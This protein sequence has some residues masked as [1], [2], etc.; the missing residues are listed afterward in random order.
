MDPTPGDPDKS[1]T[2]LDRSGRGF[3]PRP[4]ERGSRFRGKGLIF[5]SFPNPPCN[6]NFA[7]VDRSGR[8]FNPRPARC[9]GE[10]IFRIFCFGRGFCL[11]WQGK[12]RIINAACRM[13]P[14]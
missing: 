11:H 1:W 7:G 6:K 12:I 9:E 3:N 10:L 8:R 13:I 5:N 2:G 14:T 4:A